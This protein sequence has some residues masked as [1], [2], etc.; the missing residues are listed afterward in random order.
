MVTG[1][2][3]LDGTD[4]G[5]YKAMRVLVVEDEMIIALDLESLV[6]DSG[7]EVC[8]LATTSDEAIA[9]A[10]SR[11]PDI[12]LSDISLAKGT[13]G[14]VAAKAI[15]ASLDV[16]IIFISAGIASITPEDMQAV[17]PLALIS[18]PVD[19]SRVKAALID[20]ERSLAT[21]R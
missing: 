14:I 7:H 19:A 10:H 1:S 2:A 18:K 9:L 3:F 11:K 4:W 12:I 5:W 17:H 13:S 20:A 16:G 21:A 15:R 8:G 6:M